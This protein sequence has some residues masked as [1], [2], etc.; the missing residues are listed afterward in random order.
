MCVWCV[1][2]FARREQA[3]GATGRKKATDGAAGSFWLQPKQTRAQSGAAAGE[4]RARE[5]GKPGCRVRRRDEA[6]WPNARSAEGR[7]LA[8]DTRSR[9]G[10]AVRPSCGTGQLMPQRSGRDRQGRER[11]WRKN[12]PGLEIPD[13]DLPGPGD[14]A[15]HG[16][17]Q[18][19]RCRYDRRLR[20]ACEV[21][22]S[23]R[24]GA[25]NPRWTRRAALDGQSS[26]RTASRVRAQRRADPRPVGRDLLRGR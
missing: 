3:S 7:Y 18:G 2:R 5:T 11:N 4:R 1:A 20:N 16:L 10:E 12:D 24:A 15:G 26:R 8:C 21:E 14:L 13:P 19:P 22:R 9:A 17:G 23:R 6:A 25:R